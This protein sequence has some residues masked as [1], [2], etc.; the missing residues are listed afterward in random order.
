MENCT[1]V[2]LP[3][4][5]ADFCAPVTNF[6]GITKIYLAN[7][8]NPLTNVEDLTEWNSRL[9]NTGTT[10]TE[11]RTLHVVASKPA[12]EK[13][14][15]EFSL[16]RK[17][18]TPKSHTIPVKIDEVNDEN[19]ELIKWLEDNVGQSILMWHNGGKYMYGG[20]GGIVAT[21]TLDNIIPESDE[22]LNTFDGLLTFEGGHPDRHINPLA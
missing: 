1:P 6:G 10:G 12:P 4:V 7:I 9:S 18:Y 19:Y 2:T 22:E 20:N 14:E 11:I 8:G 15:I 5:G 17:L 16:G 3:V 13:S 21:L